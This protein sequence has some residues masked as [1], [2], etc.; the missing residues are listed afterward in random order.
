MLNEKL[1]ENMDMKMCSECG[2]AKSIYCFR[3][4]NRETFYSSH[5]DIS[6]FYNDHCSSC[7]PAIKEREWLTESSPNKIIKFTEKTR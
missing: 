3:K 2:A 4:S 7:D 1:K 5:N 6:L